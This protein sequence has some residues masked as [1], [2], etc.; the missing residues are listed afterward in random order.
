[1]LSNKEIMAKARE[2][3]AGKWGK[4][5]LFTFVFTV[6]IALVGIIFK[7]IDRK[8]GD[9]IALSIGTGFLQ[10]LVSVFIIT[11]FGIGPFY[12]FYK[13]AH[14]QPAEIGDMLIP[15]GGHKYWRNVLVTVMVT[16]CTGI[17][18]MICVIPMVVGL[19]MSFVNIDAV[20]LVT[21]SGDVLDYLDAIQANPSIIWILFAAATASLIVFAII[22]TIFGPVLENLYY[23]VGSNH[24]IGG[25]K[26]IRHAFRITKGNK[27]QYWGL[28]FR[29]TGWYLLCIVTFGIAYFWVCNYT[30]T[31]YA[32]F[33]QE[34]ENK[35]MAQHPE[36]EI[37]INPD[38][39]K[40]EE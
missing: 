29:F 23:L 30:S 15:F 3:L 34:A 18:T 40:Q 7:L 25:F 8:T 35:Y 1:M 2:S 39:K 4:G 31:S 16:I 5:A 19:L 12:F 36:D 33:F 20:S 38:L 10:D 28:F 22:T 6:I 26:A 13:I 37:I 21:G 27:K 17:V 11:P 24:K 32:I 9:S 14:K